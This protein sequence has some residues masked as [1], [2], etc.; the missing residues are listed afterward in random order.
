MARLA[1]QEKAGFYPLPPTVTELITTHIRA[2]H[3]GRIL[4]PCCGEGVALVTLAKELN[5]E[6]Y[7]VEL[8]IDRAQASTELINGG[9]IDLL[10]ADEVHQFKAAD[11]DQGYAFY[12]LVVA[13]RK[14]L[15]MTGT[16]FGGKASSLFHLLYR[17]SP[18]VRRAY[19]DPDRASRSRIRRKE[20]SEQYG[21]EQ[22]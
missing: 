9:K 20:W 2:P 12:D 7:G 5:L 11:S 4:D 19:T 3:G 16:I 1:S 6:P 15:A 21:V 22:S 17:T 13:S 18:E 10:L 14:V 8:N